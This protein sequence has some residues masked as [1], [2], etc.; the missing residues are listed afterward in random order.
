MAI[1][2]PT[3]G[4]RTTPAI[5]AH[6]ACDF[7]KGELLVAADDAKGKQAMGQFGR[8][9]SVK[10][11]PPKKTLTA[12]V[13]KAIQLNDEGVKRPRSNGSPRASRVTGSTPSASG[14]LTI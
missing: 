8:I 5:K 2:K 3:R 7:W 12:Y 1:R 4:P 11:L 13:K 9:T 10:D 14:R 6:C